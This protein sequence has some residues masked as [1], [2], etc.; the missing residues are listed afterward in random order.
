MSGH[1][2]AQIPMLEAQG[3]E[4]VMIVGGDQRA[5]GIGAWRNPPRW[6]PLH[7]LVVDRGREVVIE[8]PPPEFVIVPGRKGERRIRPSAALAKPRTVPKVVLVTSYAE[9]QRRRAQGWIPAV[10]M[11]AELKDMILEVYKDDMTSD[12]RAICADRIAAREAEVRKKAEA[13]PSRVDR[14]QDDAPVRRPSR[15]PKRRKSA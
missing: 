7:M 1:Y 15:S 3:Y 9:E 4:P 2:Q 6:K 12:M 13:R 11:C 10:E 8:Y 5:F 14:R